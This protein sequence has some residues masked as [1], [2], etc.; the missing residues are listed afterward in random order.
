M[1]ALSLDIDIDLIRCFPCLENMYIQ[2]CS[3]WGNL[4]HRNLVRCL[5]IRLRTIVLDNYEDIDSTVKFVTFFVL[6]AEVLESITVH[7]ARS[8]AKITAEHQG[9]FQLEKR[10]SRGAQLHFR[11][12]RFRKHVWDIM[13]L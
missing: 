13:H 9:K 11:T 3:I 1:H 5:D 12:D 10:A 6:N 4:K 8:C 7:V 2:K